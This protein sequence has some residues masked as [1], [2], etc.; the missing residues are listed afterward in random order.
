MFILATTSI[1]KK[2]LFILTGLHYH[3]LSWDN[4][5]FHSLHNNFGRNILASKA[6]GIKYNT[7]P[8][9]LGRLG[10][11]GDGRMINDVL[12]VH[13]GSAP[14]VPPWTGGQSALGHDHSLGVAC[15]AGVTC[16][17]SICG[18]G[19]HIQKM[20]FTIFVEASF[21][22]K[23]FAD[24]NLKQYL[25]TFLSK[26]RDHS[27]FCMLYIEF[28]RKIGSVIHQLLL[29][30]TNKFSEIQKVGK[31]VYQ[32]YLHLKFRRR[33]TA[34]NKLNKIVIFHSVLLIETLCRV[35]V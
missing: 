19:G 23:C 33:I 11:G 26:I 9:A 3:E 2:H 27:V 17:D 31:S 13:L 16:L 29:N 1:N 20:S 34:Y 12:T 35:K 7:D 24:L 25:P 30:I 32:A 5:D 6:L 10:G 8:M 22:L 4:Y 15:R 28:P 21:S 18:G 14:R